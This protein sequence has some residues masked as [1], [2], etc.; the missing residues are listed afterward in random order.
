MQV[1]HHAPAVSGA[2]MEVL[3]EKVIEE[4]KKSTLEKEKTGNELSV[5]IASQYFSNKFG[6]ENKGELLKV[7]VERSNTTFNVYWKQLEEAAEYT[8]EI[9]KYVSMRWY[10]LKDIYV[11]RNEGY[12]AITNLVGGGYVFRVVARD[13]NGEE[14]AKS[15]GIIIGSKKAE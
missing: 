15:A 13:R 7:Y 10:K 9:Y 8:V 11:D 2:K 12:I 6:N 14:L 5:Q 4:I 1:V 3:I